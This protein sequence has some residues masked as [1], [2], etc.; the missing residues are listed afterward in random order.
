[1]PQKKAGVFLKQ[2]TSSPTPSELLG[3]CQVIGRIT[4]LLAGVTYYWIL[5]FFT[6]KRFQA[7]WPRSYNLG[8]IAEASAI[9][10]AQGR[11]WSY[12][13]TI[14][15]KAT[16]HCVDQVCLRGRGQCQTK[17]VALFWTQIKFWNIFAKATLSFFSLWH[18]LSNSKCT[19]IA[20]KVIRSL[21]F[22]QILSALI[23]GR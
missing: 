4:L 15:N 8:I 1:M 17:Y 9:K 21:N 16:G 13:K 22:N 11:A 6:Q 20:E 10:Y 3:L 18:H 2:P 12:F 19:L 7:N 14:I 23:R 5:P